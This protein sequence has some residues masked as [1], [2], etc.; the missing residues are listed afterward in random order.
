MIVFV[1]DERVD[2][3]LLLVGCGGVCWC[4]SRC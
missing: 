3:D 4:W 1:G 2:C